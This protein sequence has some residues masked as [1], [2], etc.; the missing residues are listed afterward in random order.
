VG[1]A[2][3]PAA[4][5]E[6]TT[7]A[8]GNDSQSLH[9]GIGGGVDNSTEVKVPKVSFET[10]ARLK[11]TAWPDAGSYWPWSVAVYAYSASNRTQIFGYGGTGYGAMGHQ[12]VLASGYESEALSFGGAGSDETQA[13]LL[14]KGAKVYSAALT[15]VG[16]KSDS[17]FGDP[18]Y[19]YFTSG[20]NQAQID[21]DGRGSPYLA[22]IDA[23][24]DLDLFAAGANLSGWDVG[25]P[26]FYR[27]TGSQT[28][29]RFEE[30][31]ALLRGVT[32]GFGSA[33]ALA[34]LNADGTLDL[35]TVGG[36]C[37]GSF[38]VRFWWNNGNASTPVWQNNTT[39]FSGITTDCR[40][41]AAFAD[42]DADSDFDLTIG[43]ES[44]A[45]TYLEN[46]GTSTAPGWTSSNLFRGVSVTRN[47]APAF[48]DYDGDGDLDLVIGN[49]TVTGGGDQGGTTALAYYR[50]DG[51]ASAPAFSNTSDFDGIK[52][53]GIYTA[54]NVAPFLADLDTDGDK[55]IVL[56]DANGRYWVLDGRVSTPSNVTLDIGADGYAEWSSNGS[57]V[58]AVNI[59]GLEL[60]MQ[61]SL[62]HTAAT[63]VDAWGNQM[64]A[65][66]IRVTTGSAGQLT[67]EGFDIVYAYDGT[68]VDFSG[69]LN[70]VRE[71]TPADSDGNIR[72]AIPVFVASQGNITLSGVS[73]TVDLPP[74]AIDVGMVVMSED[75]KVDN[76]VDLT[77]A[78]SDDFTPAQQLSFS[79]TANSAAGTV[80]AYISS[81]RYLGLDAATGAANDN[82]NGYLKVS[83]QAHDA[84]AMTAQT[85]IV[86]WVQPVN[87]AP[88]IGGIVDTYSVLEDVPWELVAKGSDVDGDPLTWWIVGQPA[89]A[90]FDATNGRLNWTPLNKDV[91]NH[92]MTIYLSDGQTT[93]QRSFSVLVVNQNDA[94]FILPI[95]PQIAFEG[96]ALTLDLTGY[97][98]DEDDPPYALAVTAS[99][100]HTTLAGT[101]L[102]IYFPKDSRVTAERVRVVV[103]DPQGAAAAQAFVVTVIAA[104]PDIV[105]AGVPD[106][107]VVESIPKT[108]DLAP[109]LYNV[110]NLSRVT[111]A[112]SSSQA[113]VAGTTVTFLYAKG[114]LADTERV[115]LTAREENVSSTWTITVIIVRL[116]STLLIA[117]LP[118][119]DVAA[120]EEM[121]LELSPYLH[122]VR[123]W[124]RLALTTSSAY[125]WV[126][127]ATLHLLYPR[128]AGFSVETVTITAMEGADTS[129]D[130]MVV[131]VRSVGGAFYLDPIPPL[132]VVE[133]QPY[134]LFVSSYVHNAKS[135]MSTVL[136]VAS[137]HA[138]VSG[139]QVT[140]LYPLGTGLVGEQVT[141]TARDESQ[142]FSTVISVTV[143]SV[144]GAFALAGVP[145]I[146]AL[147]GVAFN[148]TLVPYLYNV[149]PG[150][151]GAVVV[152]TSSPF[153]TVTPGPGLVFLYPKGTNLT[154]ESVKVTAVY[155]GATSSQTV[156]V[157]IR[158]LGTRLAIA[159]LPDLYAVE[160]EP[161][162]F[163]LAPFIVNAKSQ[164]LAVLAESAYVTVHDSTVLRF[165][166]PG[167]MA[168]DEVYVTVQSGSDLA[169]RTLRVFIAQRN[170][171]PR[172]LASPPDWTGQPGTTVLWDLTAFFTDEENPEGLTFAASDARVVIDNSTKSARFKIP[173][174][175][176]FA[177]TFTAFDGED[178]AL[179]V[180]SPPATV[181]GRVDTTH[182]GRVATAGP[183][184]EVP[185]ALL[186]LVIA[187][188]LALVLRRDGGRSWGA[189]S[190]QPTVARLA[191]RPLELPPE[192][193][194]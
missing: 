99:S 157:T 7:F 120:D 64:T 62:N 82:W 16:E 34:D 108:I 175:G 148:L 192:R 9:F 142:V 26:R 164:D 10:E 131:R 33:P 104:G 168:V 20:T 111:M 47:S 59:A 127:D 2:A 115:A 44:G 71:A 171:P 124:A 88:I 154:R 163:D 194:P 51:N 177:I 114:F 65:V 92:D 151:A 70:R 119:L 43:D 193:R 3:G 23:D 1:P 94:P 41:H 162:E 61:S 95:P 15:V 116:G 178:R 180:T 97:Y 78:F 19:L 100:P 188:A 126:D 158:T 52:V 67:L 146:E 149:D 39:V 90:S 32:K 46:T 12:T 57:W 105:L 73:I 74:T 22:D 14:P 169:Q 6:V 125:A 161:L 184:E 76:L 128:G 91:G 58:G 112:T 136:S 56:G 31:P 50:N 141:L 27:N 110:K 102:T 28:G 87:D 79:V 144:G 42:L 86:V 53:G 181:V 132:T 55:D 134:V 129:S 170:D 93:A 160:D 8:D 143:V 107:Q 187:A 29:Y 81:G 89:G 69:L 72:M 167:S 113:T 98:G 75:T 45:L 18:D 121:V 83:V 80:E 137:A 38:G 24:G 54:S 60:A 166:Y 185:L 40:A 11:V 156:I 152:S 172:L 21:T 5:L 139:L 37:P 186:F 118:D 103:T 138:T 153:V 176:T 30:Q 4:A 165:V 49:G 173:S 140:F 96:I 84:H 174:A 109:Y 189:S 36:I 135:P 179:S 85:T 117:D 101:V 48:V 130:T 35:I 63:L 123:D 17:G 191:G 106:L 13:I 183:G 182:A 147:A 159:P 68:T 145:N 150:T 155:N 77:T 122:N 66:P 190:D 133:G 25:G